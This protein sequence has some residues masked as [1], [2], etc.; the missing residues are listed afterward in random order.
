MTMWLFAAS[1]L[2]LGVVPCMI[3]CLRG[4]PEDAVVAMQTANVVTVSVLVLL[5]V[6]FDRSVYIDVALLLAV[7]SFAGGMVFV[8]SLEGWQ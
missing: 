8:R 4:T 6:G 7:L 2:L 5:S 3:R 1:V